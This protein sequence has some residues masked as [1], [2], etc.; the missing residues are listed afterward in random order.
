MVGGL[1]V[2]HG[3]DFWGK[4]EELSE[5]FAAVQVGAYSHIYEGLGA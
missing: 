5:H 3:A 4:L 1:H 2:Q